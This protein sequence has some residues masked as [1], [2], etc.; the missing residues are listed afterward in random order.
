[1][2]QSTVLQWHPFVFLLEELV[3]MMR[4]AEFW[5]VNP[6]GKFLVLHCYVSEKVVLLQLK[7]GC[8]FSCVRELAETVQRTVHQLTMVLRRHVDHFCSGTV[9]CSRHYHRHPHCS[10]CEDSIARIVYVEVV[11]ET[12]RIAETLELGFQMH[13]FSFP[14]H[15][16]TWKIVHLSSKDHHRPLFLFGLK[17][18]E[19]FWVPDGQRICAE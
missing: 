13:L 15:S 19:S 8:S 11:Q 6:H 17:L 10:F 2:I 4:V 16:G 18:M 1:M 9:R 12:A 7:V 14:V 5:K 3:T